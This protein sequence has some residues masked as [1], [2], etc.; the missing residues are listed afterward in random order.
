[1]NRDSGAP[2]AVRRGVPFSCTTD[3]R[4]NQELSWQPLTS[5]HRPLTR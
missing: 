2:A 5:D 4:M 3:M 1:M